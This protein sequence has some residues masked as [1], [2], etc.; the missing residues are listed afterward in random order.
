M[1]RVLDINRS[2]KK[3]IAKEPIGE[4][5]FVEDFGL[6]NDAHAGKWHR[7]VSLLAI[8]SYHRMEEMGIK[9]LPIG[10]F[11]ENITTEGVE[12]HKLPVGTVLR[13]GETVQEVTQIGKECHTMCNIGR[14]VG[15]CVMPNEG[16]FTRVLVGGKI[17]KDD[18]IE[19]EL[20]E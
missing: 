9:D 3:G 18:T 16:I 19:V 15:K 2:D 11:G 7:Q 13:I 14:T 12:L 10:A 8:E 4:G 5:I 17:R 20:P 1:A 6:E